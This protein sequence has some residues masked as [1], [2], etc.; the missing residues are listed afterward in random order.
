MGLNG[1]LTGNIPNILFILL[2]GGVFFSIWGI[3]VAF[4]SP[5]QSTANSIN[6]LV[7]ILLLVP[8]IL[9]E[10]SNFLWTLSR[11]LP[12]YYFAD[13]ISKSMESNCFFGDLY[14]NYLVLLGG[15]IVLFGICLNIINR[16]ES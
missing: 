10:S 7:F 3:F 2:M 8:L 6:S 1:G 15:I 11:C 13:G 9:S 4:I 12:S 14:V 5:S 16:Q